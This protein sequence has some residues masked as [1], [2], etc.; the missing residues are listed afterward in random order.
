M[1][2]H[3]PLRLAASCLTLAGAL[4]PPA[5]SCQPS[6]AAG[7]AAQM[8]H[9]SVTTVGKGAPVVLIPGLSSPRETW[10]GIVPDLA[11]TH[12]VYLVQVNGFG[13]DD[14]RANLAP[15]VLDGVVADLHTFMTREKLAGAPVVGHSMGGLLA[16]KLAVAHP[17]DAGRLMIVDALPFYGALFGP[18]ATPAMLEPRAA[19][20]RDAM[21]AGY[22]KPADP[23]RSQ[24][25][26]NS[27]ALKPTSRATMLG[28]TGKADARVSAQA[29][30]EDLT[31]DV[32][33]D[34]PRITVPLT[35]VVPY[36][37]HL[38]QAQADALYRGAYRTLPHLRVV[39]VPDSAHF[40]MLDQPAAFASALDA[41]LAS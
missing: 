20:M 6:P 40:V 4:H 2:A 18:G 27:M 39:E 29:M 14:P 37:D 3:L 35:L 30:Y 19:A 24:A 41:F 13:G 7:A 17:G 22:G 25:L 8:P 31:T 15:G 26:V 21:K 16:L 34:L 11:R 33:P 10:A 1:I 23:A 38:P 32:T 36:N 5:A 28:W 12:R 9:I